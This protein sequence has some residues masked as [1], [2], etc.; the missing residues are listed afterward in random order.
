[1]NCI[2]VDDELPARELLEDNIK[3]VPYLKL[4][5]Q[6]RNA[7]E[8]LKILNEHD[9]DLVFLDIQMPGITGLDL[10][11]SLQHPPMVVMVT[12][13]EEHALEG[14]EL[15]VVDYLVKPVSFPRFL[16]AVQRA[17][18]LLQLKKTASQVNTKTTEHVFVNANYAL[19]KVMID[20]IAYIEGLKDYVRIYLTSG[21]MIITRLS[22][23][24]VEAKLAGGK[25]MRIHK[26]YIIAVDKIDSV[27][28]TQLIVQ[29]KEL[30]IGDG[31][32]HTVQA[33]ISSKNL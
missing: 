20:E 30:P 13:L 24:S 22:L 17:N 4:I 33:Y 6:A 8:A 5:G 7:A 27:Q 21:T 16:K 11:G 31:Y 32:R 1:M 3:Q 2:I 29:G 19:V 28:K 14:F 23:K 15:N 25:F 26:S 12:A 9:V 10:L 18:E